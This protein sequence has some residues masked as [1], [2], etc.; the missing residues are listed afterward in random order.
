MNKL[1]ILFLLNILFLCPAHVLAS[2]ADVIDAETKRGDDGAFTF[3]VTVQHADEGWNH[4]ATHW[5]ILD[6]DE[7]LI[8][9]RKLMHSYLNEKSFTRSLPNV[10]IPDE[11]AEVIIG[12]FCSAGNSSGRCLTLK[13]ER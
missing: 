3:N 2:E 11:V 12:A 4:Y 7:K 5:L 8:A 1:I 10:E 6:K 13:I 9:T